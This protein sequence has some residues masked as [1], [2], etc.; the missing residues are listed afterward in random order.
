[1]IWPLRRFGAVAR[2][3]RAEEAVIEAPPVWPEGVKCTACAHR[4]PRTVRAC[5]VCGLEAGWGQGPRAA[6]AAKRG[7][8][9]IARLAVGT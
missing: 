4:Q 1:M 3:T 6:E 2:M 9:L 7:R 8:E 5:E